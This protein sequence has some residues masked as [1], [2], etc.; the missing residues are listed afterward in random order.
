MKVCRIEKAL[1]LG[2]LL[3]TNVYGVSMAE[4]LTYSEFV[5][6]ADGEKNITIADSTNVVGENTSSSLSGYQVTVTNGADV[7]FTNIAGN[8][9]NIKGDG[10][11]T[12]KQDKN[13]GNYIFDGGIYQRYGRSK[14]FDD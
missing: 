11:I 2:L 5:A 13:N 14:F 12:I 9:V 7:T 8:N 10:D 3:S 1:V 6:L 4:D